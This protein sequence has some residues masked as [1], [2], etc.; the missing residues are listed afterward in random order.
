MTKWTEGENNA[1]DLEKDKKDL[2]A[3]LEISDDDIYDAMK[4]IQ[5]YL[6]ITPADLREIYGLAYRHALLR[7]RESVKAR[8]IMTRQVFTVG[9]NTPLMAVAKL[10]AGKKVSGIPVLDENGG[11]AGI[12]SEKDFLAHMGTGDKTHIMS[13]IAEYLSGKD[14]GAITIRSQKAEDIM[15]TPAFTVG[16]DT[17]M[18]EIAAIFTEKRINRVPVINSEGRLSGIVSRADIVRASLMKAKS[19]T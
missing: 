18:I 8:D 7:I 17:P 12:I 11:I 10:M 9:R 19:G 16:E 15:T 4:D 6:D 1:M 13:V 2:P 3:G 5:G 14:P